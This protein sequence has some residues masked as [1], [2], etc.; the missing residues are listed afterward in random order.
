M[1]ADESGETPTPN[2]LKSY[3][4]ETAAGTQTEYHLLHPVCFV[5]LFNEFVRQQNEATWFV[6]V[7]VA[8]NI[9]EALAIP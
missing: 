1:L 4:G 5:D 9:K 6:G 3:I 7:A 8:G 2:G